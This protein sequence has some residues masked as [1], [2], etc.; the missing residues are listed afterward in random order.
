MLGVP[1][2]HFS[3][4]DHGVYFW[5]L[6]T[7]CL[8][9]NRELRLT[10][11]ISEL[12]RQSILS[13]GLGSCDG[14]SNSRDFRGLR[15][16]SHDFCVTECPERNI[17]GCYSCSQWRDKSHCLDH[18]PVNCYVRY[19]RHLISRS[20]L[21][22]QN[23]FDASDLLLGTEVVGRPSGTGALVSYSFSYSCSSV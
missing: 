1:A 11:L 15:L 20:H 21:R 3:T 19:R 4:V 12:R 2:C 6:P 18:G 9:K 22:D 5:Q 23:H 16:I 10:M 8:I 7:Q 17:F 13:A 14:L